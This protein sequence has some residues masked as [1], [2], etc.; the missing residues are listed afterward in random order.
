MDATYPDINDPVCVIGLGYVGIPLIVEILKSSSNR[1]VYGYDI[2]SKKINDLHNGENLREYGYENNISYY[3][4]ENTLMISNSIEILKKSKIFIVAVPTPVDDANT[5]DLSFM[6]K[7]TEAIIM[8]NNGE[9]THSDSKIIIYE[10]TVYPGATRE[11][12]TE[13]MK[14]LMRKGL[15]V[16]FGYSPERINPGDKKNTLTNI[17]KITSGEDEDTAQWIDKFYNSFIHAGTYLAP[18]I[19]VAEAAKL[20]E[21]TQR[22][23]NIALVNELALICSRLNIDTYEVLEA[24]NTKWNFLDFKPGL[25]GGHCIGVD[26][27][28]LAYKAEKLGIHPKV[29]LAG[30]SVNDGMP[31]WISRKIIKSMVS[32]SGVRKNYKCLLMG[33]TFKEDCKDTRNSKSLEIARILTSYGIEVC[34]TDP[35]LKKG[36]HLRITEAL[37]FTTMDLKESLTKKFDCIIIS[38]KHNEFKNMDHNLLFKALEPTGFIYDLKNTIKAKNSPKL[39]KL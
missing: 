11:I 15:F 25:V 7:A 22:D 28:Y 3:K 36:S 24:A 33:A 20:I 12:F 8:A 10:S 6:R 17:I 9:N 2:S 1:E 23:I 34:I 29:I 27:Y 32:K 21:N 37:K 35:Y 16:K 18:S 38:V 5:P 39:K 31:G 4:G 14:K 26:P 13:C 19:E 30:R